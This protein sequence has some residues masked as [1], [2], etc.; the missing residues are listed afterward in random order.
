MINNRLL[1]N[2]KGFEAINERICYIRL[3]IK[4]QIVIIFSCHAPTEE[5]DVETKDIFYDELE[6]VYN[7]TSRHA[8]KIILEDMNAK[9]GWENIYRPTIGKESLHSISNDNGARLIHFAMSNGIIIS[10]TY[11]QRKDI[12]KQTW[13]SPDATTK[14]QIYHVMIDNKHRSWFSYVRSYRGADADTDY[15]LVVAT[16][17]EKLSILWKE[18]KHMKS[19]NMLNVDRLRNPLEIVQYRKRITEEL[20]IINE[21]GE[22]IIP[23]HETKWTNIKNVITS[24]A[25]NLK[26]KPNHNKKNTGSIMSVWKL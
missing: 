18:N 24:A 21:K 3:K 12:H 20:C 6:Q 11:F 13:I 23:Y 22:K 10:S 4:E 9:I 14:N 16:L 2:V 19:T 5:K 15:Y 26:E 7:D 8:I 25:K 17:T 1:E